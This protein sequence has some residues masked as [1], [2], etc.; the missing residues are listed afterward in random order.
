MKS[1][2]IIINFN[3][4]IL[5]IVLTL[6]VFVNQAFIAKA[7]T[8]SL[9]DN[10]G[11]VRELYFTGQSTDPNKWY[12]DA[13]STNPDVGIQVC[14]VGQTYV[15]ATYAINVN[16]AWK[17][18]LVSYKSS[19]EALAYTD[20]S[21][22]AGCYFTS[23]G[24]LTISPSRLTTPDPDVFYAAFPGK[25]WVGYSS[26]PNPGTIDNFIFTGDNGKLMGSY[27]VER[28]FSEATR[29]I[30][31]QTPIISFQTAS[32]TFN[33][34]ASDSTFGVSDD[35]R[36]VVGCCVDNYG[37]SCSDGY[38][39]PTETNFP[40]SLSSGL[41]ASD[42]ND[43]N[44]Y[45]RYI[46]INGLGNPICIGANLQV[47]I[48]SIDPDPVYYGQTLTITY[49]VTNPR[50]TPYETEG[51]NVGVTS[52][53]SVRISIYNASDPGDVKYTTTQIITDDIPVDGSYTG[54]VNWVAEAHSGIY[55]VKVE[56]D[57][58]DDIAECDET[59]N[60][61]TQNFELK[62]V[63][64]PEIYID[65]V[66]T[67]IFEYPGV[68][69]NFSLHLKNSDGEN[70]S[71]A[72]IRIVEENGLNILG[73]TQIWN[74]SISNSSTEKAGLKSY[75]IAEFKTDYLGNANM[76][77]IPTGN[78]LYSPQYNYTNIS[79]YVGNYRIYLTG[80]TQDNESLIFT[81]AGNIQTTYPLTLQNPYTY[82]SASNKVVTNQNTFV[83]EVLDFVYEVFSTFWKSIV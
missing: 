57:Y 76:T 31:V 64:I 71:N 8:A 13:I 46:V 12:Q 59:D 55:T 4:V 25:L 2:N 17:Y 83:Q 82:N 18:A 15:G 61:A 45:T 9:R 50:D 78:K 26:S 36:M 73:P 14:D 37:S 20:V 16:G 80:W 56:V 42:V 67:T 41:G 30:T 7:A 63:Y 32:S 6:V 10:S 34:L 27:S 81:I 77:L 48:S 3:K 52:S 33:K 62:P 43:Q 75:N 39:V 35:R 49:S 40:I 11:T 22:G 21:K 53:F 51:G 5:I 69:Y 60:T 1:K 54:T 44:T 66:E 47:S 72:T 19:T 74:R 58:G 79:E 23:P 38:V 24:Y 65:G 29:Q 68:P 70:V 28:S